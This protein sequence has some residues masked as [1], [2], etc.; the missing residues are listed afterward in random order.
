MNLVV[1]VLYTLALLFQLAGA[2]LVVMD[3]MMR[4]SEGARLCSTKVPTRGR[5]HCSGCRV[6]VVA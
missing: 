3:V 1:Y 4:L 2:A 6:P 5:V